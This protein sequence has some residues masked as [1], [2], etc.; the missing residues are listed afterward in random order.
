MIICIAYDRRYISEK[1]VYTANG[2]S[3]DSCQRLYSIVSGQLYARR[4]NEEKQL[5]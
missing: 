3:R 5:H 1:Y 2:I 4:M